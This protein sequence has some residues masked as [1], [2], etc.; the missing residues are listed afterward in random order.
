MDIMNLSLQKANQSLSN[1]VAMTDSMNPDDVKRTTLFLDWISNHCD[2]FYKEQQPLILSEKILPPFLN[3][4][5]HSLPDPLLHGIY[6]KYYM[7]SSPNKWTRNGVVI[8]TLDLEYLIR[9][10]VLVPRNVVWIDFGFNIGMEFGG[11][12]PA[13][14]LRSFVD[15]L[16]VAPLSSGTAKIDSNIEI[17]V[18]LVYNFNLRP[19]ITNVCWIRNI[20]IHRVKFDERSGSINSRLFTEIVTR[21]KSNF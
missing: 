8:P 16:L 2:Y 10:I 18:P 5:L 12:H 17:D 3:S 1:V 20:S 15:T 19:R 4:Y 9:K 21:I 6:D 7:E 13:L 11:P 14:I